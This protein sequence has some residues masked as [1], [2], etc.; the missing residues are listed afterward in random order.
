MHFKLI[1][2]VQIF[3][4]I[5]ERKIRDLFMS[6]MR[7]WSVFSSLVHMVTLV[8]LPFI[9][10]D[11]H[12]C[13]VDRCW[14]TRQKLRFYGLLKWYSRKDFEVL[15]PVLAEAVRYKLH[16]TILINLVKLVF[17]R[18]W[19]LRFLIYI[20]FV[21]DIRKMHGASII[22]MYSYIRDG[23]SIMHGG[24]LFRVW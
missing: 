7:Q 8:V 1:I 16:V 19:I 9:V 21:K 4:K 14:Y 24:N 13:S 23:H 10:E 18:L 17:D 6:F 11:L 22:C 12:F 15:K 5:I 2:L 20:A 3:D